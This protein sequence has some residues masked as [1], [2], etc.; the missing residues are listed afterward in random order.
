[1]TLCAAVRCLAKTTVFART[2]T[3]P[4]LVLAAVLALAGGT[5]DAETIPRPQGDEVDP[6]REV[7]ASPPVSVPAAPPA[8]P[9]EPTCMPDPTL[10]QPARAPS[11]ALE[12]ALA[13][14][15]AHP[16]VAPHDVGVSVWIDGLGEV[17][18][19]DPDLALVPASSRYRFASE[20]SRR[21]HHGARTVVHPAGGCRR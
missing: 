18:A 6:G 9:V 2:R 8:E 7:I 14:F 19:H 20:W 16:S 4:R 17:L 10:A 21:D 11:P 5:L 13:T 15:L 12:D 1:M 3:K